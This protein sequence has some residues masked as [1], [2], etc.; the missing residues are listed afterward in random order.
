MFDSIRR[1]FA[2][3]Q[4]DRRVAHAPDGERWYVIGDIHGRLDLLEA[5]QKAIEEDDAGLAPAETTVVF[6]GDLVDRGPDSA[7]VIKLARKWGKQRKVR[8]IAGNHEEM[9]LESFTDKEVARHFLRHG[10]RETAL[11]YGIDRKA[12]NKM[13]VG[14]VQEALEKAVPK[15][16]R[17]FLESF[18]DLIVVGDYVLVHA[19]INPKHAIGEQKASD[20]R[21]IRDRFLRHEEPFS[22]VVVHGHTIFDD[23]V[24]T[25]HRIGIDTGAFR[26]GRLTA[27]VLEGDR[28]R[29]I[30]AVA[31][32]DGA[33]SVEKDDA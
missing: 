14:E 3:P 31:A 16:D 32:E 8:Y 21:W 15:K 19:G 26:T 2:R 6:L 24:D 5:L 30:K 28:R 29:T 1:I 27:L 9:F 11:S 18:E 25:Q 33:I 10:G 12:Y 7:G 13:K 23:V 4:D 22:H 17:E 20:L